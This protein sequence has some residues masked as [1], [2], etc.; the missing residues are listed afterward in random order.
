MSN[1]RYNADA[2]V[3]FAWYPENAF[4]N[5]GAPTETELN[6]GLFISDAIAGDDTDINTSA[7][8]TNTEQTFGDASSVTGRGAAQFGGNISI[9]LPKSFHDNSNVYSVAYDALKKPKTVGWIAKRIDGQYPDTAKGKTPFAQG[10]LVTIYK[11]ITDSYT[12]VNTG[13]NAFRMTVN[14]V[15]QGVMHSYIVVNGATPNVVAVTGE[16]SIPVGASSQLLGT[17]GGRRYTTGLEYASSAIE[18]ATVSEAG[19]VTGIAAGTATITATEPESG[20]TG[21]FEVTIAS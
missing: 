16:A 18:T 7:S 10:D 19:V 6:A 13:T 12:N 20:A 8:D 2:N 21:T 17:F 9:Y 5:P 15:S 1:T 11:V 4:A 3:T 14:L